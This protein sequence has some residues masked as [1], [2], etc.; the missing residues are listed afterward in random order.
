MLYSAFSSELAG[1]ITIILPALLGL[2]SPAHVLG[3]S[4]ESRMQPFH[5]VSASVRQFS[6]GNLED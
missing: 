6:S 3:H 2:P 4:Q 5:K 1:R